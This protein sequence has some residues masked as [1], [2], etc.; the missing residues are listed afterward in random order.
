[1]PNT[2]KARLIVQGDGQHHG[3]DCGGT[4][5]RPVCRISN[6]RTLLC[7]AASKGLHVEHRDVKTAFFKAPVGEDVRVLQAP[8]I[9]EIHQVTGKRQGATFFVLQSV[10]VHRSLDKKLTWK[11]RANS[12]AANLAVHG[13]YA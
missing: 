11:K 9:E 3:I 10:D 12:I 2:I 8:G 4:F 1:M 5:A 13:C 7:I 6:Q